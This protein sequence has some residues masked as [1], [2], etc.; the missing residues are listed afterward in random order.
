MI[1]KCT[2]YYFTLRQPVN[3]LPKNNYRTS[4]QIWPIEFLSKISFFSLSTTEVNHKNVNYKLHFLK[5]RFCTLF[6]YETP[7]TICLNLQTKLALQISRLHGWKTIQYWNN[8]AK[9]S[10]KTWHKW[11]HKPSLAI[12]SVSYSDPL[13]FSNHLS[14]VDEVAFFLAA[15]TIIWT[16]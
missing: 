14:P 11:K 15:K 7:L 5:R 13:P 8:L 6:W 4:V 9:N 12:E 10:T 1:T 3:H 16:S 2:I